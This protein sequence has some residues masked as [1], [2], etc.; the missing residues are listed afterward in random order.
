VEAER[1]TETF[2]FTRPDIRLPPHLRCDCGA[3][4]WIGAGCRLVWV[5]DRCMLY[6]VGPWRCGQCSAALS[7]PLGTELTVRANDPL[8]RAIYEGRVC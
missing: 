2:G 7:A 1:V 6:V 8:V 4:N 5:G 3:L